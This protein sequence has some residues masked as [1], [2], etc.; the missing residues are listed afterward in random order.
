[1]E[2]LIHLLTTSSSILLFFIS[3]SGKTF[4][5]QTVKQNEIDPF[6]TQLYQR[7]QAF[8]GVKLM[9]AVNENHL[10]FQFIVLIFICFSRHSRRTEKRC[11]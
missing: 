2:R 7:V 5:K 9:G 6:K 3:S 4:V 11:R 10:S 1:M 8:D